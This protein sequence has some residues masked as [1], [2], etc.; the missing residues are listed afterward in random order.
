[1][2]VRA[3]DFV[4]VNVSDVER[5]KQFYQDTLGMDFPVWEFS[6][7]WQELDSPPVAFALR[8]DK[9]S[10]GMNAAIAL[11]VEDVPAAIEEL[12]AK[13]V[14][15]TIEPGESDSCYSAMIQDPDGN[16]LLIH[17]RKDGTAG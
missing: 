17:Q 4:V 8:E 16:L 13:G 12:R 3:I 11:A 6:P 9:S 14:P 1:M 15:I 7:R 5:S 10:P 2:K